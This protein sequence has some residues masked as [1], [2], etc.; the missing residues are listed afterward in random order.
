MNIIIF[1]ISHKNTPI[2]VR[3]RFSLTS[4]QQDLLL[5]ELKNNPAIIEAFVFSTCNR[6]E[7][8][9]HVLDEGMDILPIIR[10]IFLIK[11]ISFTQDLEQ[12]FYR[13]NG[14]EAIK[15]LFKVAT[16]LDSMVLGERQILGQVKAAFER[17]QKF[18]M[19][20][21]GFNI[22]SN[23]AIRSGKKSQNETQISAGGSSVSWAAITKAEQV[24]GSLQDKSILIIG[25]GKMSDLAAA[26]IK[27]K[28]FK[29]LFL[30]NRTQSKAAPLVEKYGGEVAAFCDIKEVLT[31]VDICICSVSAPHYIL[32][33]DTV[34]KVMAL[35]KN[36]KILFIDISMPRNI[37]PNVSELTNV[38]L[39]AIDDLNEVVDA[40]MQI[41]QQAIVEV[42]QIVEDK[43]KE[44]Y[45]KLN[46]K[47]SLILS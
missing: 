42:E 26:Q 6:V 36:R 46:N 29:K 9:A 8:Y 39:Y 7:V 31:E 21:K 16:G 14:K 34:I 37:N 35:R 24:L 19:F 38:D 4:T 27:N 17:A 43:V 25:A 23:L 15:H 41:R 12:Y 32:E 20:G 47:S 22:L 18:A 45:R 40:N 30:M 33:K 2:E 28:G 1:G 10:V 13:H 44:Y 3:E 5:S 11:N